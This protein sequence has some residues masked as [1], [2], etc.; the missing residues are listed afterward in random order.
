MSNSNKA[1]T[2][3]FLDVVLIL[4]TGGFWLIWMFIRRDLRKMK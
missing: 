2:C 3:S 4:V 1:F